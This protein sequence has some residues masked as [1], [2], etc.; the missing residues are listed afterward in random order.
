LRYT[1]LDMEQQLAILYEAAWQRATRE[2]QQALRAA[3]GVDGE[4]EPTAVFTTIARSA[5]RLDPGLVTLLWDELE[6]KAATAGVAWQVVSY[7]IGR[8]LA[9]TEHDGEQ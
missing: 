8:E 9:L 7:A 5:K 6:A 1:F 4:A 2:E 3:A